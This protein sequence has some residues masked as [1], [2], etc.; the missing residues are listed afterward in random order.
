ML[1]KVSPLV[2]HVLVLD[3]VLLACGAH[4]LVP[5]NQHSPWRA[6]GFPSYAVLC[7]LALLVFWVPPHFGCLHYV[8]METGYHCVL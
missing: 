3:V 2:R 1:V 7:R 4:T 8:L 6:A 5:L